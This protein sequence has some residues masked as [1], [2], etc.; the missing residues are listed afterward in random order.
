VAWEIFKTDK[1]KREK[2][3]LSWKNF[4]E[5]AKQRRLTLKDIELIKKII[6]AGELTQ[7]DIVF[8]APNLYEDCIALYIQKQKDK[9]DEKIIAYDNLLVLRQHMGYSRLPIESHLSSSR[10]LSLGIPVNIKKNDTE[11]IKCT[12]QSLD[13][14]SWKLT[15][16]EGDFSYF[17]ENKEL[18]VW[19][20][21]PGDAEYRIDTKILN[22]ADS[23]LELDHS[24]VFNRKQLR[25][26]V[27]IDVNIPCKT[28]LV[29]EGKE[30]PVDETESESVK[31]I[32]YSKGTIFDGRIIDIS[33]GGIALRL[34]T[35]LNP[36]SILSLNFELPGSSLR[37][38]TADVLSIHDAGN[39]EEVFIHRLKFKNIETAVQEK[40]IRFV[41]EKS[42]M[43]SQFN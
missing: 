14:K 11:F 42:R 41:F 35:S 5:L 23:F 10:Q 16:L 15:T 25:N 37:G 2:I 19:H 9:G 36:G 30:E 13:E 3:N 24:M 21:R 12:I 8:Q 17:S 27:R 29:E 34:S 32:K 43:D 6:E 39:Q 31:K 33:G 38:I 7:A 4:S 22:R 26:W 18:S 1:Q 40:V 20:I 28:T